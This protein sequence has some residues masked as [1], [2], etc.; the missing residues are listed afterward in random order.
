VPNT[1]FIGNAYPDAGTMFGDATGAANNTTNL[2]NK[3]R[4][5]SNHIEI[6]PTINQNHWSG[7]IQAWKLPVTFSVRN[8]GGTVTTGGLTYANDLYTITGLSATNSNN[9]NQYSAP[10]NL[11]I[12]SGCY[13]AEPTFDF[14]EIPERLNQVPAT[15]GTGDFGQ[16]VPDIAVKAFTGLDN[17]FECLYIKISGMS[18][19]LNTCLIKTWACVEYQCVPGSMIYEFTSFSPDQDE[20]AMRLYRGV[21]KGLPIGVSFTDNANFWQRVLNIIK[22]VSSFGSRF[23]GPPGLISSGVNSVANGLEQMFL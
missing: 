9:A 15:M 21:I 17:G 8:Y 23:P 16:L 11:G 6:I 13:S 5:I 14:K 12:Y 3:Y 1:Q 4:Y 19:N 10:F 22:G 20:V 7:S 18:D 2:V